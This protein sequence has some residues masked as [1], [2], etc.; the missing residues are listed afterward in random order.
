MWDKIEC[1]HCK[2]WIPADGY[3]I[4]DCDP[5]DFTYIN[6]TRFFFDNKSNHEE[7]LRLIDLDKEEARE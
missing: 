1:V 2:E 4:H 5:V 6:F 3:G 7:L